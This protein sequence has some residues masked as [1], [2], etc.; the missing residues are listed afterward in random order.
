MYISKR[1]I[2]TLQSAACL[3]SEGAASYSFINQGCLEVDNMDDKEEMRLVDVREFINPTSTACF[4][5]PLSYE[6]LCI[7]TWCEFLLFVL[8][9][10]EMTLWWKRFTCFH[11][12]DY[13][14]LINI[15][16]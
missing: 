15:T 10:T 9:L 8:F 1:Y 11:Y 12:L 16:I 6:F 13:G 3:L 14:V 2:L 5:P 7:T 4:S